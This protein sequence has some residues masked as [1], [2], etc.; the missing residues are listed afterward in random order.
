M[1]QDVLNKYISIL[2]TISIAY[3]MVILYNKE[4]NNS[5]RVQFLDN[6]IPKNKP[7]DIF[8]HP[9]GLTDKGYWFVT[10]MKRYFKDHLELKDTEETNKMWEDLLMKNFTKKNLKNGD[11]VIL[12]NGMVGAV[13]VDTNTIVLDDGRFMEISCY[14][15]DLTSKRNLYDHSDDYDIM[16]V[17]R[18]NR[19]FKQVKGI[20]SGNPI[21]DR[22]IIETV[23]EMTLE[24]VCKALG[25]NIKIVKG[26]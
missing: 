7:T 16:K 9:D 17:Y 2:N 19:S 18:G 13:I 5:I 26:E 21:Y 10:T 24:Q 1:A 22:N 12:R 14:D 15:A 20:H 25:K 23:E 8:I 11:F 4:P 3:E 6:D